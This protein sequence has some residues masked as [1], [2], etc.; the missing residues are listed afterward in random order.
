MAIFIGKFGG[1]VS[2]HQVFR[3]LY[4][5]DARAENQ[6]VHVIVLNALMRG[7]AVVTHG[8]AYA[9][10]FIGRYTGPDAA[11]AD[12]HAAL[13]FAIEYGPAHRFAKVGVIGG[14]FI[15]GSD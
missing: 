1:E 9:G 2:L 13:S 8:C 15:E 11:A 14:I 3:Q 5:N 7:V 12:K 10:Q 4:A 6:N